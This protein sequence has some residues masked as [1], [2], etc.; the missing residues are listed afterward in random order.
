MELKE[1]IFK[2]KKEFRARKELDTVTIEQ[3]KIQL[4]K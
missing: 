4:N 1:E 3:Q 2:T